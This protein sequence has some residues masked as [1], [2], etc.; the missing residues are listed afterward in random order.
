MKI[1][2]LF[3]GQG[4]QYVGMCKDFYEKYDKVKAKYEKVKEITGIDIAEISFNGDESV[5]NETKN[6]QLAVLTM[7]LAILELLKENGVEADILAGLS[8]GEYAALIHGKA[9]AFE[10]GVK[11]VQKRGEFMQ[12]LLPDGEWQM[13]AIIGLEDEAIENVC[14]SITSGFV[15][16]ANYNTKGQVVISGEKIAVE[17][18]SIIAKEKGAKLVN[19]IKTSGPFH[20]EKL[21]ES[22]KALREVLDNTIFNSFETT[23]I[24]NIDGEKYSE[25]DDIR[26]VL[27]KHIISPVRF[28]KSL[29]TMIDMG[30]DTFVEVG[31]GKTLSGFAKRIKTDRK[32]NIL[33]INSVE[34]FEDAL[35]KLKGDV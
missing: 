21:I 24:K 25:Q 4:A 31:P 15:V 22:A 35:V 5:L 23:V 27:E 14:N 2:F 9:L 3:P 18:A 17:E 26:E 20:T 11:V 33:N 19:V 29:Q 1:G 28:S 13:A 32:I 30:V 8:L 6:T 10:D 7:S 12:N 16:P 34:T